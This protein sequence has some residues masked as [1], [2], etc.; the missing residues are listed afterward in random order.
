MKSL[1]LVFFSCAGDEARV[2][3]AR[4]QSFKLRIRALVFD[5]MDVVDADSSTN[6]IHHVVSPA[7]MKAAVPAFHRS[8]GDPLAAQILN[9]LHR[10]PRGHACI[11]TVHRRGDT[12]DRLPLSYQ[13]IR[14]E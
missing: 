5:P 11:L 4:L 10:L 12:H 8:V 7:M 13:T 6:E 2:G 9:R 14:R 1:L 3:F